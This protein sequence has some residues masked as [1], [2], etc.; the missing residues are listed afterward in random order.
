MVY[1]RAG[2]GNTQDEPGESCSAR[3]KESVQNLQWWGISEA[4][5]TIWKSSQWPKQEQIDQEKK[6]ILDYNPRYR[7]NTHESVLYK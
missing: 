1:S 6:L 5:R 3:K 2:A 4:H 7:T